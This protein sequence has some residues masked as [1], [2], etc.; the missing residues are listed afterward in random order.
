[1]GELETR[2]AYGAVALAS[3]FSRFYCHLFVS[4]VG[5]EVL[6]TIVGL[7]IS[8]RVCSDLFSD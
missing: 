3:S 6:E 2:I 7:V 1:M 5:V 4:S 8:L